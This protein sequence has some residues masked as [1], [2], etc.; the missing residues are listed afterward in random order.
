[1][2]ARVCPSQAIAEYSPWSPCESMMGT[3]VRLR[4]EST[5]R[6]SAGTRSACANKVAQQANRFTTTPRGSRLMDVNKLS[7]GQRIAAGAGVLLFID[8]WLDGYSAGNGAF[9][10]SV[11]GWQGFSW[12]DL[13]CAATAVVAVLV[14]VQ[15]MR[16]VSIPAPLSTI[17]LPLAGITML[18]VLYRLINQ[19][20][21]NN[22]VSNE[23]GAYIGFVLAALTTSGPLQSQGD[24]PTRPPTPAAPPPPPAV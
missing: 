21:P 23:F 18:L 9:S 5:V 10:I 1:M 6:R 20:G 19:P 16:M 8:L 14:A 22:L 3:Y 11:S 13:L 12:V 2:I 4:T 17:L 7:M 24:A 15:A